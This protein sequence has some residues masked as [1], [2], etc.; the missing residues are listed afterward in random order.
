[1]KC[2]EVYTGEHSSQGLRRVKGNFMEIA[3][4][5]IRPTGEY[6]TALYCTAIHTT[7]HY[8]T[9]LQS[10]ALHIIPLH[11]KVRPLCRVLCWKLYGWGSGFHH[12][13]LQSRK[14]HRKIAKSCPEHITLM[15]RFQVVELFLLKVVTQTTTVTITTITIWFFEFCHNL[16]FLVLSQFELLNFV[17][18]WVFEFCCNLSLWVLSQFEFW[19]FVKIL[20]F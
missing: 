16:I 11:W 15:S 6:Y 5:K 20:V 17:T 7:A 14:K 3:S 8:C 19:S 18:I 4:N 10:T 12:T 9:I 13:K 2:S 1:M